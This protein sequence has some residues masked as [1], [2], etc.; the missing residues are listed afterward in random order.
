MVSGYI[1]LLLHY[2]NQHILGYDDINIDI[3]SIGIKKIIPYTDRGKKYPVRFN[4]TFY[5]FISNQLDFNGRQ[6]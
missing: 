2:I 3:K 6:I 4:P 1:I 5:H